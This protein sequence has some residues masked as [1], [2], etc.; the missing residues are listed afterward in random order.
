[1]EMIFEI[2]GEPVAAVVTNKAVYGPP[3]SLSPARLSPT[4]RVISLRA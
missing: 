2:D 3:T 4:Y 1:M